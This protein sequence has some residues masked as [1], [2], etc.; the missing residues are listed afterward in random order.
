MAEIVRVI[1]YFPGMKMSA[2]PSVLR[3]EPIEL[4]GRQIPDRIILSPDRFR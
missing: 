4:V 2:S 1:S 3:R